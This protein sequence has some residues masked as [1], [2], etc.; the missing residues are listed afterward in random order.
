[1]AHSFDYKTIFVKVGLNSKSK[2][3]LT[4]AFGILNQDRSDFTEED[5]LNYYQYQTLYAFT[6]CMSH[7]FVLSPLTFFL[8]NFSVSVR[9]LTDA[10]TKALLAAGDSD[11]DS[12]IGVDGKSAFIKQ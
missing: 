12:K 4:K 8:Q 11:G 5:E 3:Q 1:A 2:D 9:A 6:A 10:E 7:S